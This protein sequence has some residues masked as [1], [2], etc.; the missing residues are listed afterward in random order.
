MRSKPFVD[1]TMATQSSQ[2]EQATVAQPA[3]A[4]SKEAHDALRSTKQVWEI[5]LSKCYVCYFDL[6]VYLNNTYNVLL[7]LDQD[8]LLT[9]W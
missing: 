5:S 6:C 7:G 1:S 9:K 4:C 8:I 2:Q 3:G